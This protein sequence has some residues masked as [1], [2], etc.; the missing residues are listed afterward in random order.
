[1]IV[2]QRRRSVRGSGGHSQSSGEGLPR[3]P[4]GRQPRSGEQDVVGAEDTF[5]QL[6]SE[7]SGRRVTRS[8]ID[9]T[10]APTLVPGLNRS[11]LIGCPKQPIPLNHDFCHVAEK[12]F[13]PY[14]S[15]SD[16]VFPPAGTD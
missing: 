8:S 9:R 16:R 10:D 5:P 2:S 14:K 6:S 7:N 11:I 1:Q 4:A 3:F 15:S 13:S 12:T